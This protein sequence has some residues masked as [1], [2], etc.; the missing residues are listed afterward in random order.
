MDR[1]PIFIGDRYA[2][3]LSREH[4]IK[5]TVILGDLH[6]YEIHRRFPYESCHKKIDRIIVHLER[7]TKLLQLSILHDG[8]AIGQRHRLHL[9]VGDQ[10]RRAFYFIVNTFDLDTQH[11]T[12][13][14][15]KVGKGLVQQEHL[16]AAYQ[17]PRNIDPLLLS[18]RKPGRLH[19]QQGINLHQGSYLQN[20]L[21]NFFRGKVLG[22]EIEGNILIYV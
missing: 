8:N 17:S 20:T 15:V 13:L 21:M 4:E 16:R 22:P 5:M 14:T 11:L 12:H 10:D 1:S 3:T 18:P 9:V 2:D 6:I 19:L 7:G